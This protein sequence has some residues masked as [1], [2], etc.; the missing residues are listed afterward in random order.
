V[1]EL[2]HLRMS[3]APALIRYSSDSRHAP[4]RPRRPL[5][6]H[7]RTSMRPRAKSALPS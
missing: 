2:G 4:A 1:S 3:S 6:G 5:R 7:F